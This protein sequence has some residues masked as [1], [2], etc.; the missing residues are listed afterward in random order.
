MCG[1]KITQTRLNHLI[2]DYI[3][4]SCFQV[5]NISDKIKLLKIINCKELK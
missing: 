2:Y 4:E 3:S 5:I 1:K